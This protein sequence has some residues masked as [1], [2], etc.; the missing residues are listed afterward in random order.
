MTYW[1]PEAARARRERYID[2]VVEAR[3]R[4]AERFGK[5]RFPD[6]PRDQLCKTGFQPR[7]DTGVPAHM[8]PSPP[9]CPDPIWCSGN[10]ICHWN[11]K[12]DGADD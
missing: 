7:F 8:E 1:S 3:K 12:N 5:D 2:E 9:G 4:L 10:R 6:V 11:C